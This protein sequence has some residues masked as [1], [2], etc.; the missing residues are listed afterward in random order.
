MTKRPQFI[1]HDG[2]I[3]G[4]FNPYIGS[5]G[6]LEPGADLETLTEAID[7]MRQCQFYMLASRFTASIEMICR[8]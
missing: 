7:I 1:R 8:T 4:I 6:V 5:I 3:I 2:Q